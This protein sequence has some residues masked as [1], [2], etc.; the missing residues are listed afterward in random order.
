MYQSKFDGA[1]ASGVAYKES[2]FVDGCLFWSINAAARVGLEYA[3][4]NQT[5]FNGNDTTD[6]RF[7]L[8]AFYIF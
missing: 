1:A 5:L 2:N 8:S 4:F 6:L 3:Y 7:Q